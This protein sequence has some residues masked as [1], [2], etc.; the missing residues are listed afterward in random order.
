MGKH[1][2]ALPDADPVLVRLLSQHYEISYAKSSRDRGIF[3]TL[4]AFSVYS[5]LLEFDQENGDTP[6]EIPTSALF[7]KDNADILNNTP[8][9]QAEMLRDARE[10]LASYTN[11]ALIAQSSG[12]INK[13]P[14][15]IPGLLNFELDRRRQF[16]ET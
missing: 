5:S 16:R 11:E 3:D 6:D 10:S 4:I 13:L 15:R 1:A 14:V 8:L 7:W 2:A 9:A 12:I